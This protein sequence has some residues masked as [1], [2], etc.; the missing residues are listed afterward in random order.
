M[1]IFTLDASA[2][3]EGRKWAGERSLSPVFFRAEDNHQGN[4]TKRERGKQEG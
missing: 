3:I 1:K 4:T 2:S